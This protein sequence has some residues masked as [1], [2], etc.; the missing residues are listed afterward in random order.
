MGPGGGRV[1][2]AP[3]HGKV[4]P[5]AADEGTTMGSCLFRDDYCM[6]MVII[7]GIPTGIICDISRITA[8][9]GLDV[10]ST[11]LP[12][13]EQLDPST[14]FIMRPLESK[15]MEGELLFFGES[16]GCEI[17]VRGPF[18][19]PVTPTVRKEEDR[20]CIVFP[21]RILEKVSECLWLRI[22]DSHLN[23][24]LP[25]GSV[26]LQHR[27]GSDVLFTVGTAEANAA[28]LVPKCRVPNCE[29]KIPNANSAV[30]HNAYHI[31]FTP[32]SLEFGE[33]CPVCL[34]DSALCPAFLVKTGSSTLQ[35]RVFCIGMNPSTRV[36]QPDT[37]LK[38]TAKGMGTSSR[39]MPSSN[40][41]IVCPACDPEL[42]K[43]THKL[44]GSVTS[45]KRKP[46]WRKAVWK[47]NFM[48]HWRKLHSSTEMPKPLVDDL[49]L[50]MEERAWLKANR[51]Y[52]VST[53]QANQIA[54]EST[55][56]AASRA[57]PTT[58]EAMLLSTTPQA[59]A[60]DGNGT[61]DSL[62]WVVC[63]R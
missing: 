14:R 3:A 29:F 58:T 42:A 11:G 40:I 54:S 63:M 55:A 27:N 44:P 4:L 24:Q 8:P 17:T 53:S 18:V 19:Q 32:D 51:G 50:G 26:A 2:S 52:K 62:L 13:T 25:S 47:F 31:L 48:V 57:R 45:T 20:A 16:S 39:N 36:D 30:N 12:V 9:S 61:D 1:G 43:D 23:S 60:S 34:G 7:N 33:T 28:E 15:E 35:P 21:V 46:A 38:F 6:V 49:K 10:S 56:T 37:Y 41:P 59:S 22:V 5:A